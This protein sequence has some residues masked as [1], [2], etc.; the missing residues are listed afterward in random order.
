MALSDDERA[1][2]W[3]RSQR[4]LDEAEKAQAPGQEGG[5]PTR[6]VVPQPEPAPAHLRHAKRRAATPPIA[7]KIQRTIHDEKG[8]IVELVTYEA[9]KAA[10]ARSWEAWVRREIDA[11]ARQIADG[12]GQVVAQLREEFQRVVDGLRAEIET[13]TKGGPFDPELKQ[14]LERLNAHIERMRRDRDLRQLDTIDP[15]RLPH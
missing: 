2:I 7:T 10:S 3:E 5:E 1:E 11:Q 14:A 9:S 4:L 12:M 13:K 8:R 6:P 15:L